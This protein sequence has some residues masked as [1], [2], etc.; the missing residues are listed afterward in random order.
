M[1]SKHLF[2][3]PLFS[4]FLCILWSANTNGKK[5]HFNGLFRHR[6][7]FLYCLKRKTSSIRQNVFAQHSTLLDS[8]P[9]SLPFSLFSL[10]YFIRSVDARKSLIKFWSSTNV[11]TCVLNEKQQCTQ[12]NTT[13]VQMLIGQQ[14][15]WALWVYLVR[16]CRWRIRN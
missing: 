7:I 1:H 14:I 9:Y 6:A 8:I 3:T 13:Y 2:I 15:A 11:D 16:I 10:F 4:C 5:K 12:H